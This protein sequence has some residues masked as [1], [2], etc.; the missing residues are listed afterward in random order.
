MS[1]NGYTF[2]VMLCSVVPELKIKRIIIPVQL[3]R[4]VGV[5]PS[6][7]AQGNH[8]WGSS[9]DFGCGGMKPEMPHPG[10]VDR[11]ALKL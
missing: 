6:A 2:T 4:W 8:D 9:S 11:M 5:E 3:L 10:N 1:V 7:Q